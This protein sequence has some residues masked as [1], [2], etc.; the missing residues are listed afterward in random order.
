MEVSSHIT[1]C[2]LDQ[3]LVNLLYFST[4]QG[5]SLPPCSL[6]PT[7][8]FSSIH[9][10]LYLQKSSL[11]TLTHLVQNGTLIKSCSW[12]INWSPGTM[13]M[14]LMQLMTKIIIYFC[15]YVFHSSPFQY[16]LLSKALG[17]K[18][19]NLLFTKTRN[20]IHT[21]KSTCSR[22]LLALVTSR[23]QHTNCSRSPVV[24]MAPLTGE[25]SNKER[26]KE[27]I[28]VAIMPYVPGM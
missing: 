19:T 20:P 5:S 15:L 12:L 1:L 17:I 9:G 11:P 7:L 16:S 27:Y 8:S 28:R 22:A 26:Q 6:C 18:H 4:V 23:D 21:L 25:E 13:E 10:L 14:I 3:Q 2:F 24:L